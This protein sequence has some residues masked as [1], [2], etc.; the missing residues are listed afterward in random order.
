MNPIEERAKRICTNTFC[1]KPHRLIC[2]TC[3]W[4]LTTERVEPIC[5]VSEYED[6]MKCVYDS[7]ICQL[8]L[9][10][11]E[12]TRW[13]DPNKPPQDEQRVI[14]KAV[15]PNGATFITGGWYAIND[16]PVGWSVDIDNVF[17]NLSVVGW[18]PI[19]E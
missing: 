8:I 6:A 5:N 18:R 14:V 4:R 11:E 2:R 10:R 3:I 12:L 9:Q 7:A 17:N 1:N 19:H 16:H 13:C 15:L